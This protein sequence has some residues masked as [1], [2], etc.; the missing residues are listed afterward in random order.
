MTRDSHG[1]CVVIRVSWVYCA[2]SVLGLSRYAKYLNPRS[3]L[4]VNEKDSHM[5]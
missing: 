3:R 2:F 5:Q 4:W 1:F